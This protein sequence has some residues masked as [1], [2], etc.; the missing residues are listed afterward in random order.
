[1]TEDKF[2][3]ARI[4]SFESRNAKEMARL[5]EKQNGKPLSAPS[6]REVPL[7][8]QDEAFA[9][10]ER[11][12]RGEVDVLVLL[13]GV[14][15]RAL[16]DALA[17]RHPRAE[18][19]ERLGRVPLVCRGP[20]PQL[21][22]KEWSLAPALVAPEP[23]TTQ[24][25]IRELDRAQFPLA[26]KHVEVQEYGERNAELAEAL[27]T[28]GALVRS[29]NVYSWQLP[30]DTAPLEHAVDELVAGRVDAALFTSARQ[31]VHLFTIAERKGVKDVLLEQLRAHVVLASVGPV[32]S[33]AL[34]QHGLRAD[35]EPP[36]PKMGSFVTHV[37]AN[38][39]HLR[40]RKPSAA[41]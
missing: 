33:D 20:K 28:R 26:G 8:A 5:I 12:W 7:E 39:Q 41:R 16:V 14:G 34:M 24:D 25:L 23:N 9:F 17:T 40:Q 30:E 11:L 37:A 38:W 19:V 32:T 15:L 29:V 21:V 36:H 35:V 22:L 13:T 6:L 4:V 18:V 3:G 31:I 10:G 1:M 27:Q 2:A